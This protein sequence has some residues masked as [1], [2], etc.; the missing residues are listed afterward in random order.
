MIF[1]DMMNNYDKVGSED[2]INRQIELV[3]DYTEKDIK[4]ITSKRRITLYNLFYEYCTK[5]GKD[6]NVSFSEYLKIN[7]LSYESYL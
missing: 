4:D 7:N 2:I 5:Y 3:S 6:F 1:Y